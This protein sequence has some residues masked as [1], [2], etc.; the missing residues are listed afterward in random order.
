MLLALDSRD[1]LN[2]V[3]K[4]RVEKACQLLDEKVHLYPNDFKRDTDV[5]ALLAA[6]SEEDGE[7]LEAAD[8]DFALAGRVVSYRSFGKV[9]FFHLQ[10]R[11]GRIQVYAARDDLGSED[12]QLFKKTDIGDIV[13]IR[14][15]LFRTKTGE[16]TVKTRGFKL[17]T[18]SLRP[19]PEKY[20]G[21]KDVETRYRQRYVD[22][23]VTPR[24]RE[25]F[26]IRTAVVRELRNFLDEKGFMEVETPMMQAIPGGATAKPFETHH[27]ALDMK[28][29]MRIAPELYLKRLLVGGF[30][31]VYEINR[32]FRNEGISTQHNPEFTM[33][34]FYWAYANFTDLMDLTEEMFSRVAEKVTGSSVVP[35]QGEMID[36]SV[37]A[38][39]RLPFHESLE[40]IGGIPREVYSDYEQCKALVRGRGEK[41][42]EGDKLGK[43]QAKLFD[44]LVEPK[45]IQ[46][47][48]I[49][50]YPTDIS[51]LSRRNE[52]NPDITD[53]FEL[54]MTGREMAN[55]FSELNDPV[56][57]RGRFEEQ[58]KEKEAGDEEAHF[59]DEDYVRAL[60]YGMPPAAGQGVGID[61]LVM[62]LTDSASIR[63][64]ILFPLL[65]P[66]V[67]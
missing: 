27:N 33:L 25:I 6:Y 1:E 5:E 32:N 37:G 40:K 44:I 48:F 63:E 45:L 20:H 15:S 46:P 58:V 30:D 31:R 3:I 4:T 64:V 22:L 18:K 53:R 65:R 17:I 24:T 34:E 61:R 16:L 59:M 47:H 67:G 8:H 39:T 23:I 60:E 51:P 56:D 57:Q 41:V 42:V 2:S 50:H 14:G 35:Y 38:W 21:L 49:Y 36:L 19:L 11:G 12:Y 55:A 62:L 28:L 66:E 7:T 52:E 13:G 54:F 9:T 43:L 26:T 10:G 29:Y